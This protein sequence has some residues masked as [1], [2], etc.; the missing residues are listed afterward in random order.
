MSDEQ[1]A[2]DVQARNR[3]FG[4]KLITFA[5]LMLFVGAVYALHHR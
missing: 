3:A 5:L 2:D 4:G 1:T